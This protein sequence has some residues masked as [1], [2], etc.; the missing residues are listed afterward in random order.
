MTGSLTHC[1]P[2]LYGASASNETSQHLAGTLTT[3]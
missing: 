3:H 2:W 1:R